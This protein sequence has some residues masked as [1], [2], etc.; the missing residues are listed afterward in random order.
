MKTIVL[1]LAALSI[2]FASWASV[3][4]TNKDSDSHDILIKCSGTTDSS[5]GGTST[6]DVGTGPCTV[7]VKSSG[8]SAT[9]Q[10][11]ETLVIQGGSIAKQ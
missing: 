4:L 2:T 11:G 9:A 8:S 1:L 10:D 7:T 6:R 3:K 5:V